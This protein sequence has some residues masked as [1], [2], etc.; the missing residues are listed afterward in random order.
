MEIIQRKT[1]EEVTNLFKEI[2]ENIQVA[3]AQ[4]LGSDDTTVLEKKGRDLF[5]PFR[6]S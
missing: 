4:L 5:H 1:E 2:D 6:A 3:A